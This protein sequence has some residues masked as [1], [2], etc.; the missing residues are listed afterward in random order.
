MRSGF[1]RSLL[2]CFRLN[3]EIYFFIPHSVCARLNS[4]IKVKLVLP[5]GVSSLR[6]VLK[7]KESKFV[8]EWARGRLGNNK[9]VP[10]V[11]PLK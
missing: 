6:S 10:A 9:G 2:T 7:V 11:L 4:T 5:L 1:G 8:G 3:Q